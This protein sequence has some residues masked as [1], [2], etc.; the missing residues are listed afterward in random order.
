VF[1][2]IPKLRRK[3]TVPFV[4]ELSGRTVTLHTRMLSLDNRDVCNYAWRDFRATEAKDNYEKR[5]IRR[6][7][8]LELIAR[9]CVVNWDGV[10]RDGIPVECTPDNVHA[11]LRYLDDAG[12]RE[13]ITA[14]IAWAQ[15]PLNWREPLVD[16][17]VVG[18]G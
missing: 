12:Y 5:M 3:D 13:E 14:F 8:D 16:P 10:T 18:K 9:C 11:F 15:D 6:E 17:A 7:R 1:D 2:G 4:F